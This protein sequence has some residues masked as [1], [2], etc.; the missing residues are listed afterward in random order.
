MMQPRNQML[1]RRAVA[2]YRRRRKQFGM[3][4]TAMKAARA[5]HPYARSAFRA[6]A[7]RRRKDNN[8]RKK[9]MARQGIG[10]KVGT[11]TCKTS[12]ETSSLY[13]LSAKGFYYEN[14]LDITKG[15]AINQRERDIVNYRGTKVCFHIENNNSI[16]MYL[17]IC[18]VVPKDDQ[19]TLSTIGWFR[20]GGSEREMNHTTTTNWQDLHC[21]PINR[22]KYRVVFHKRAIVAPNTSTADSNIRDYEFWIP[23]RRQLQFDGVVTVPQGSKMFFVWW[24]S[25][26]DNS[27]ATLGK[28]QIRTTKY[29]KEP[30]Q[31]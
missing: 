13:N 17:N 20:S 16:K 12:E 28:Y 7:G 27:T 18:C 10:E 24:F 19:S 2:F 9:R 11:G 3:I 15:G 30:C 8:L 25:Y 6:W 26:P 14:L 21:A 29:F 4:P 5:V 31:C 1:L 23:L 22:D